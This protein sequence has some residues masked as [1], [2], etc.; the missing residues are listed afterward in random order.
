LVTG[1]VTGV[2]GRTTDL[3]TGAGGRGAG[4]AAGA[5]GCMRGRG[6]VGHPCCWAWQKVIKP[7]MSKKDIAIIPSLVNAFMTTSN[8]L[9]RSYFGPDI[10]DEWQNLGKGIRNHSRRFSIAIRA[11]PIAP[12]NRSPSRVKVK[13]GSEGLPK[14][15]TSLP[16]FF[17]IS[18]V[19]PRQPGIS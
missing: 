16:F 9:E 11:S 17:T 10:M 14:D 3:V 8:R 15:R 7:I 18:P 13:R 1:R 2:G 19:K 4:L 5:G 12:I 6:Q